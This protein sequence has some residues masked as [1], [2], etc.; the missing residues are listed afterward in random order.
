M[1]VP[2]PKL[3]TTAMTAGPLVRQVLHEFEGLRYISPSEMFP[4]LAVTAPLIDQ[5][6]IYF[7]DAVQSQWRSAGLL[8]YY[9]FLNLAKA[10]L[11]ATNSI[12][13]EHLK[14]I[15]VHH[16]LSATSQELDDLLGFQ[17]MIHPPFSKNGK[18]NIFSTLYEALTKQTWPF[19]EPRMVSLRDVAPYCVEITAE[20]SGL[21][22]ILPA[23]VPGES[24]IRIT[25]KNVWFEMIVNTSVVSTVVDGVLPYKLEQV[26]PVDMSYED[27]Q[28]WLS[29][30]H[31]TAQSFNNYTILRGPKASGNLSNVTVVTH[32]AAAAFQKHAIATVHGQDNLPQW[33]F[34]PTIKIS[35]FAISWHP[36]LSDYL[37]AFALSTILRYQPHL[38]EP[39]TPSTFV[40][41]AWCNQ[42]A[43]TTLR[44]FLMLMTDPPLRVESY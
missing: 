1:F 34:V 18:Q 17:I 3:P 22:R 27:R 29:S 37:F 14:A 9:S 40:A 38:F 10:Y 26:S 36:L 15:S 44:Y 5:A 19:K 16:G 8:Y 13:P 43:I 42:S 33:L 4:N 7:S 41:E 6:K 25:S 30:F 28:D 24:L 21:F 23:I 20:L 11:G 32:Q 12:K 39:G 2:I 35:D 31:R